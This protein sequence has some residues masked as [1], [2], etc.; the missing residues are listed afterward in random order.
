MAVAEE[1]I[2]R[3]AV[4]PI[5]QHTGQEA[6]DELLTVERRGFPA[7]AVAVNLMSVSVAGNPGKG[8]KA[9]A[10]PWTPFMRSSLTFATS[11]PMGAQFAEAAK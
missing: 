7:V 8:S 5:R 6:A 9:R 11:S 10:L 4:K 2:K 3:D 1:A